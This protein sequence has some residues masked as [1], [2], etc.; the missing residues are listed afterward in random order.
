M[1]ATAPSALQV[2]LRAATNLHSATLALSGGGAGRRPVAFLTR[3]NTPAA[4]P[5]VPGTHYP[6]P[7]GALPWQR[8]HP[9][10]GLLLLLRSPDAASAPHAAAWGSW[11]GARG[12]TGLRQTQHIT[13]HTGS[14]RPYSQPTKAGPQASGSNAS[15]ASSSNRNTARAGGGERGNT[16]ADRSGRAAAGAASAGAAKQQGGGGG[17]KGGY[18][19]K[20]KKQGWNG[21]GGKGWGNSSE[22]PRAAERRGPDSGSKDQG[23]R[24]EGSGESGAQER[25]KIETKV[26]VQASGRSSGSSSSSSSSSSSTAGDAGSVVRPEGNGQGGVATAGQQSDAVQVCVKGYAE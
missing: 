23:A 13:S 4:P 16:G 17:A 26:Q 1:Q 2:F 24:K 25:A 15:A 22:A 19:H 18:W 10:P 11:A 21:Q 7:A 8:V 12:L 6:L 20:H 3:R 14:S 9:K 5:N